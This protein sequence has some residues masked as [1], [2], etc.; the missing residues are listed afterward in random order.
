MTRR[1]SADAPPSDPFVPG[2]T[3]SRPGIVP[4]QRQTIASMAV[5]ALRELLR[6]QRGASPA[7][8]AVAKP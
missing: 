5:E 6:E 8:L 4:I 7:R 2:A 1:V 3:A